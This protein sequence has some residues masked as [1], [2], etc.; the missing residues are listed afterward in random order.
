MISFLLHTL[1]EATDLYAGVPP[2]CLR[3]LTERPD[4]KTVL[5]ID[6]EQTDRSL[7][8]LRSRIYNFLLAQETGK[9][10]FDVILGGR[11]DGGV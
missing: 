5:G 3:G 2:S 6:Q 7:E 10:R 9:R 1:H 8:Q 11:Q 4:A